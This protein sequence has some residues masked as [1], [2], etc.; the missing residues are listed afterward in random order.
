MKGFFKKLFWWGVIFFLGYVFYRLHE[1]LKKK[2]FINEIEKL[3]NVVDK[4]DDIDEVVGMK[5][6][7]AKIY[8]E[9]LQDYER[10]IQSL[11][12]LLDK[13]PESIFT[14]AVMFELATAYDNCDKKTDAAKYYTMLVD[15]YPNSVYYNEAKNRRNNIEEKGGQ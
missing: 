9:K 11:T 5:L 4:R 7:E 6:M 8:S 3:G 2:H 15:N 10:A 14:D 12:E 13:Y 1:F